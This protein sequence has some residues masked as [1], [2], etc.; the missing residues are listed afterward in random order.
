MSIYKQQNGQT[1]LLS[2]GGSTKNIICAYLE[3]NGTSP[4]EITTDNNQLSLIPIDSIYYSKGSIFSLKE[5]KILVNKTTS[6]KVSAQI[7]LDITETNI[8]VWGLLIQRNSYSLNYQR[9]YSFPSINPYAN[10]DFT[11]LLDVM[12]GDTIYA[13]IR[14]VARTNVDVGINRTKITSIIV[15]EVR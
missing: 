9:L 14:S 8:G 5:S 1:Y 12:S 11:V 13:N 2:G 3:G 10:M 7:S 4:S 15:E 6:V